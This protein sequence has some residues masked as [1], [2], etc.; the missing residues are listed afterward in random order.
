MKTFSLWKWFWDLEILVYVNTPRLYKSYSNKRISRLK[1][2]R[3]WKMD[4]VHSNKI[5]LW[6]NLKSFALLQ[7][8][9]CRYKFL[10]GVLR[11]INQ[12]D[13][14]ASKKIIDWN[15]LCKQINQ[16]PIE[17]FREKDSL[18]QCFVRQNFIPLSG[19]GVINHLTQIIKF[20]VLRQ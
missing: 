12:L 10:I 2:V 7:P 6:D 13:T 3:C 9:F 15:N 18:L 1:M 17:L 19:V 16:Y 14:G 5:N 11:S 4:C 20:N 8:V